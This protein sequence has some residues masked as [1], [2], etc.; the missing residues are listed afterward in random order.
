MARLDR[1]GPMKEL[2]QMA[3]TLGREFS[4]E[5]IARLSPLAEDALRAALAK[6]VEVELLY[7]RGTPPA[8]TYTFKNTLIQE[9]AYHSLLRTTRR[10]YHGS[11]A[12]MLEEHFRDAIATEPEL[13]AHHL[14]EA[15]LADRA[16]PYWASA[17]ERAA[18]RSANLEAVRHFT[19]ALE[20]L[21]AS[22]DTPEAAERE[23]A[24]RIAVAV[25]MQL[26]RGYGAAEVEAT[27][28]RARGLCQRLGET[29]QIFPVLHGLWRFYVVR[30]PLSTAAELAAS[31]MQTA[32]A[33]DDPDLLVHAGWAAGGTAFWL[34]HLLAAREYSERSASVYDEA[35]H[36]ATALV[37]GSDPKVT[38]LCYLSIT[39]WLLGYPDSALEQVREAVTLAER[40]G[41]PFSLAWATNMAAVV[42]H[43]RGEGRLADEWAERGVVLAA[44]QRF[45]LWHAFAA[46]LRGRARGEQGTGKDEIRSLQ[47]AMAGLAASGQEVAGTYFVSLLAE[48]HE[49]AGDPESGLQLLDPAFALVEKNHERF[50]EAELWRTKG[51]LLLQKSGNGAAEAAEECFRRALAI[52][53]SQRARSLELRAAMSQARRLGTRGRAAEASALL[54][55][56][57]AGFTEGFETRDLIEAKAL[58]HE[59]GS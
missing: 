42:H 48:M 37:Y 43:W 31:L 1:L 9:A 14:T 47:E 39:L 24:L 46:L 25:P 29:P 51:E 57:Y 26:V 50:Y 27:Y 11:V 15:G 20:L 52:A 16:V 28:A 40:V 30:G 10:Q 17:G 12:G 3:A 58:L 49:R 56:I 21:P 35:R 18:A 33:T 41:H 54:Q 32:E 59:L 45:P 53:R 7:Q 8:A 44:E 38:A 36:P 6:L 34:G 13:L 23:L 4:H 5:R 2:A 22:A 55:A 19:R